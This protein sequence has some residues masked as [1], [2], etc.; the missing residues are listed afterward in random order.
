MPTLQGVGCDG[1]FV[2]SAA[3][4]YPELVIDALASCLVSLVVS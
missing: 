3:A 1:G 4:L 2:T